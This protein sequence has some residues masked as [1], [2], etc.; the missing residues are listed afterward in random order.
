MW[1]KTEAGWCLVTPELRQALRHTSAQNTAR[2]KVRGA[3]A[4][5]PTL[6][7]AGHPRGWILRSAV[8]SWTL[9]PRRS[10]HGVSISSYSLSTF[11][12]VLGSVLRGWLPWFLK[13]IR[14]ERQSSTLLTGEAW[15]LLSRDS[16]ETTLELFRGS[17]EGFLYVDQVDLELRD[18]PAFAEIGMCATGA[19]E[20]TQ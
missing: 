14:W 3:P 8:L 10:E 6:L 7:T 13:P 19:G 4:A 9:G 2:L 12:S 20:M 11:C 5:V 16:H 18:L 17:G 15:G 1:D